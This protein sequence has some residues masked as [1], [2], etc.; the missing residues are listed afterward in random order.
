MEIGHKTPGRISN[1]TMP[2]G[3]TSPDSK[4]SAGKPFR[5]FER[6][7]MREVASGSVRQLPVA[8]S[9]GALASGVG[10][11]GLNSSDKASGHIPRPVGGGIRQLPVA[12]SGEA[13]ASG[14]GFVGL[15]SSDK[16]S[17]HIP[18][19]VGGGIRN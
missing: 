13:L 12:G 18:R 8:G 4:T 14:V 3:A 15:N 17:G 5:Y 7:V 10:F 2:S 6:E 9:G 11:V 16:A 19:P 1:I